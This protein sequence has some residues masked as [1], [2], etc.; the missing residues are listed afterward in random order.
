M[1]LKGNFKQE[2]RN[3]GRMGEQRSDKLRGRMMTM[4]RNWKCERTEHG[5]HWLREKVVG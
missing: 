1:S 3:I 4:Q 5:G 2:G